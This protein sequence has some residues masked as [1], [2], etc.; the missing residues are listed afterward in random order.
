[1]AV[2]FSI[3]SYSYSYSYS[4]FILSSISCLIPTA[5]CVLPPEKA[6]PSYPSYPLARRKKWPNPEFPPSKPIH[7]PRP[8]CGR[9]KCQ[10]QAFSRAHPTGPA[11]DF[12]FILLSPFFPSFYPTSFQASSRLSISL[13]LSPCLPWHGSSAL[14]AQEVS[15]ENHSAPPSIS[16]AGRSPRPQSTASSPV[17]LLKTVGPYPPISIHHGPHGI[18]YSASGG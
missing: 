8:P 6:I 1:M 2:L 11:Y 16:D 4:Y 15:T 9:R 17:P 7:P 10:R 14:I 5:C 13:S 12:S 3:L 18:S